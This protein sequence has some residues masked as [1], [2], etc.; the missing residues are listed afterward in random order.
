MDGGGGGGG[1]A[2][3]DEA[4]NVP[5]H[6]PGYTLPSGVVSAPKN[7]PKLKPGMLGGVPVQLVYIPTSSQP[8]CVATPG[9]S[10]DPPGTGTKV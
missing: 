7:S 4:S 8:G 10:I 3:A 9:G 2:T 5:R 1:E 6:V